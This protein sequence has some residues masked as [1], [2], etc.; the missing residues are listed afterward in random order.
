[1]RD[2]PGTSR[3]SARLLACSSGV[4]ASALALALLAC[5]KSAAGPTELHISGVVEDS[6]AGR[7]VEGLWFVYGQRDSSITDSAGKFSLTVAPRTDTLQARIVSGF[8]PY[9]RVLAPASDTLLRIRLRRTRPYVTCFSLSPSGLLE[10]KVV[11][12]RG[13]AHVLRDNASWV[14]YYSPSMIQSSAIPSDQWTWQG[15]DT[16]TWHVSVATGDGGITDTLWM[17]SDDE[18]GSAANQWMTGQRPC[19]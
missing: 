17:V 4:A 12:L 13:I 7:P 15:L 8:E 11:H 3:R 1:M 5:G 14:V 10:A 18:F 16:V 6:V 9:A 2:R 19:S